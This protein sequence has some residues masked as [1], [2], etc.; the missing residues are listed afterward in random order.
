MEEQVKIIVLS[1]L[2]IYDLSLNVYRDITKKNKAW[3]EGAEM[4]HWHLWGVYIAV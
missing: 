2:V 1:N 4:V 3:K